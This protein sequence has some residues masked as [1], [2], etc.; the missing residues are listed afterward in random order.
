MTTRRC[1]DAVMLGAN[2]TAPGSSSADST[3]APNLRKYFLIMIRNPPCPLT[4]L[5]VW[6]ADLVCAPSVQAGVSTVDN[7]D[8]ASEFCT[9]RARRCLRLPAFQRLRLSCR[10][11][12]RQSPRRRPP[13]R[14][15]STYPDASAK[16]FDDDDVPRRSSASLQPFAPKPLAVL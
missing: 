6:R 11:R 8:D 4:N 7:D 15:P 14:R 13:I 10:P 9:Y 12:V 1:A 3:N 2:A 5:D 16:K